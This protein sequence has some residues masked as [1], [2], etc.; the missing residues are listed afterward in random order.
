VTIKL[1][2]YIFTGHVS[3]LCIQLKTESYVHIKTFENWSREQ[4]LTWNKG[5]VI[6]SHKV[7]LKEDV[8]NFSVKNINIEG[9]YKVDKTPSEYKNLHW[10]H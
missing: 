2:V 5:C 6:Q 4:K 10:N 8:E 7:E 9:S 3:I 1:K